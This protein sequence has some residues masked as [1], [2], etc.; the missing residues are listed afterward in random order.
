[1]NDLLEQLGL[2]TPS[3]TFYDILIITAVALFSAGVFHLYLIPIIALF[4]KPK[5]GQPE[6]P[7]DYLIIVP[8]RKSVILKE[9]T[10]PSDRSEAKM[11]LRSFI[12]I[13]SPEP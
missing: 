7:M 1:M 8:D 5:P 13:I 12:M 10:N 4:K 2:Q 3:L 11:I 6:R 9:S